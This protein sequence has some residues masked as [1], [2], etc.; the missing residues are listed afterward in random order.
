VKALPAVAALIAVVLIETGCYL[1]APPLALI[2]GGVLIILALVDL[3]QKDRT[4]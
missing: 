3:S 4:P 2:V 1:I